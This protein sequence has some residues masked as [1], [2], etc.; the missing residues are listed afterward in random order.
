MIMRKNNVYLSIVYT[1]IVSAFSLM[2][3]GCGGGGGGTSGLDNSINPVPPSP[4][5]IPIENWI[6]RNP[7]PQGNGFFGIT[8]GNG[9]YVGVGGAGTIF[10]SSDIHPP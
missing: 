5:V 4:P 2:S 6:W 1:I 8:Y 10:T 3:I 7:L 9:V